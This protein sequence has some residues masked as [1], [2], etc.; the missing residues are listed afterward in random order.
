MQRILIIGANSGMAE[1]AARIWA[2]RG[3]KIYLLGRNEERLAALSADLKIRGA[4]FAGHA[5]FDANAF[6]QHPA[7]LHKAIQ[8]LEGIDVALVAHGTLPDQAKAE[9]EVPYALNEISTNA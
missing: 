9:N 8:A 2:K 6:D 4:A 7:L 3:D 1:A 5:S